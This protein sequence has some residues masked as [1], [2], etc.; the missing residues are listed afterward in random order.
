MKKN[1]FKKVSCSPKNS[2]WSNSINRKND[3]YNKKNDIRSDFA[4]DYNRILH[5]N[6]YR[7]LKHKTQVFFA[8]DH[9]HICTRI[10]H[11]NH[12]SSVS[13]T[14]SKFL[15]LNTELTKSIAI[16]HDLG[17]APFGH[18]G[19]EILKEIVEEHLDE[20][21]WHEKNSLRVVDD[22]ETLPDTEGNQEN[23]NLTY[24]VRD[25]IV[26]H[27]GEVNENSIFPREDNINL[28]NIKKAGDFSPYTWEGCVVKV[29]DKISYLGRDIE[30]AML[31]KIL[32]FSQMKELRNII[33]DTINYNFSFKEVNNT[34]LMHEFITDLCKQSSPESGIVFS[35][36]YL[37]LI[38]KVKEFNYNNIYL[39]TRLDNFKS[40]AELIIK[41]IYN[42]LF[43]YYDK[44]NTLNNLKKDIN[45]FPLV[46]RSFSDWIIKYSDIKRDERK[47]NKYK[48]KIVYNI[49][50]KEDYVRAIVDYISSM[51]DKYAIKSFNEFIKF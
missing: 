22:L 20:K 46:I 18:K 42:N 4:R 1:K 7:R 13:H 40:Y 39:N 24:G 23:L 14:I 50:K 45:I 38:N 27:C 15:G 34:V 3:L 32:S 48:N 17:H 37:K 36:K 41:S 44:Q 26:C 21:F 47:D 28:N 35:E 25:G 9:D 29:S 43:K 33:K 11:V 10:E 12:V 30:D 8:T 31:L 51:T 2:K 19:E 16:G 5:S 6:A 49:N